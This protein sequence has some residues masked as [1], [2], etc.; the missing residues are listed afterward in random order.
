MFGGPWEHQIR[1]PS[2]QALDTGGGEGDRTFAAQAKPALK[3]G[4]AEHIAQG[5][6][7]SQWQMK[8]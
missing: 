5:H 6:P 2:S 8:E 3:A 7:A 1:P 4:V